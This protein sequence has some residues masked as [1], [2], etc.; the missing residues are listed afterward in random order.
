[1]ASKERRGEKRK[2]ARPKVIDD[3]LAE[4][5]SILD[6]RRLENN[7]A[8]WFT[9]P[10][11]NGWNAVSF[12]LEAWARPPRDHYIP[13]LDQEIRTALADWII[14]QCVSPSIYQQADEYIALLI[15]RLFA[16]SRAFSDDNSHLLLGALRCT[17]I[18]IAN[19]SGGGMVYND[20]LKRAIERSTIGTDLFEPDIIEARC[21]DAIGVGAQM[22]RDHNDR[23]RRAFIIA[24]QRGLYLTAYALP[25]T[26]PG[27]KI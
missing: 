6:E 27:K 26:T 5:A 24:W 15:A 1:M 8:G 17:Q 21:M 18:L 7:A 11:R 14:N 9:L 12:G 19:S 25:Q 3:D 16:N 4:L 20:V 13:Q 10:W 23:L 2:P 22:A